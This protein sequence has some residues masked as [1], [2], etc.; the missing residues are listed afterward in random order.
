MEKTTYF[1]WGG[2]YEDTHSYLWSR[3][4]NHWQ[5]AGAGSSSDMKMLAD[6]IENPICEDDDAASTKRFE[7]M[8]IG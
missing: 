5:L 1:G 2:T 8:S 3:R 4:G 6:L 7:V